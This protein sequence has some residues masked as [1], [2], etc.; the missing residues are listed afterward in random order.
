[1]GPGDVTNRGPIHLI[2]PNVGAFNA[3][4]WRE[5]LEYRR[6]HPWEGDAAIGAPWGTCQAWCD[7]EVVPSYAQVEEACRLALPTTAGH[8]PAGAFY[9]IDL[10]RDAEGAESPVVDRMAEARRQQFRIVPDP[11]AD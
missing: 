3:T 7:G 9:L 10:E 5:M 8:I 11:P 6:V 1:M 4:I 2:G